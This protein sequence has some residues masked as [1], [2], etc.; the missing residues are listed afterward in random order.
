MKNFYDVMD[1]VQKYYD[2]CPCHEDDEETADDFFT[3]PNCGEPIYY[4]DYPEIEWRDNDS[5]GNYI[6]PIC[7][8]EF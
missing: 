3:C 5:V 4:S 2:D 7:D 8:N 1:Y 6:C